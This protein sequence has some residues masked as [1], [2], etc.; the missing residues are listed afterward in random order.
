MRIKDKKNK[1][2]RT[3]QVRRLHLSGD[4]WLL[5]IGEGEENAIVDGDGVGEERW[6]G[7]R[8]YANG[9]R[10]A[11]DRGAGGF[12][13]QRISIAGHERDARGAGFAGAG[14][15][16]T[17]IANKHLAEAAVRSAGGSGGGGFW[18]GGRKKEGA[19]GGGKRR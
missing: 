4:G 13:R 16:E 11:G 7:G 19:G 3:K 5:F 15:G 12:A 17:G 6:S 9:L 8:C 2:K 10:G 14:C 18:R 1:I